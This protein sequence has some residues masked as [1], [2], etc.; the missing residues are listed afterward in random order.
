MK[1]YK[2]KNTL[3]GLLKLHFPD[4]IPGHRSKWRTFRAGSSPEPFTLDGHKQ[5][6]TSLSWR[7]DGNVLLSIRGRCG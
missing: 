3:S 5:E 4:G 7:A 2:I 6:I 1:S